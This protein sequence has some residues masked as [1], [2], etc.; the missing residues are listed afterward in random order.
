[1]LTPEKT[2][3][4][5]QPF[6]TAEE[7]RIGL[8]L[9]AP[10]CG[11]PVWL[12]LCYDP[13]LEERYADL[14][15]RSSI[16]DGGDGAVDRDMVLDNANL[17]NLGPRPGRDAILEMVLRR[18]PAITDNIMGS[19][20]EDYEGYEMD[21]ISQHPSEPP[22]E[23]ASLRAVMVLYVVDNEAVE[24]DLIK[25]F[26][27]DVHGRCVWSNKVEPSELFAMRGCLLRGYSLSEVA[28]TYCTRGNDDGCGVYQQLGNAHVP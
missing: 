5:L 18:I 4:A 16:S 20:I 2:S 28:E 23:L 6:Q 1:M 22:I 10:N 12:R 7:R 27:M 17:Y 21:E 13:D 24:E 8:R 25:L 3:R 9:T 15:G 26:W 19:V 11:Y 14:E